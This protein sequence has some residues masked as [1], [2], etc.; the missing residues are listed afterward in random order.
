M[1]WTNNLIVIDG[2]TFVGEDLFSVPC[3]DLNENEYVAYWLTLVSN[4]KFEKNNES[5]DNGK[6]EWNIKIQN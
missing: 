4:V 1:I 6:V 2:G 5:V 3:N